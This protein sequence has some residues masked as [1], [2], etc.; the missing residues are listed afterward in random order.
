MLSDLT[1]SASLGAPLYAQHC[2]GAFLLCHL[3]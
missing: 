2:R 3:P 1:S